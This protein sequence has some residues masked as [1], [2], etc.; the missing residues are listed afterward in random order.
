MKLYSSRHMLVVDIQVK[1]VNSSSVG[2]NYRNICFEFTDL[3]KIT[4]E[5]NANFIIKLQKQLKSN[6]ASVTSNLRDGLH[7]HLGLVLNPV[8][9]ALVVS[10]VLF[11]A[12]IDPG[13][14]VIPQV[15]TAAMATALPDQQAESVRIFREYF[16]VEKALKQQIRQA[17][18]E[19]YLL[20]IH[21]RNL[22]SLSGTVHTILN[23]LQLTY[24][25]VSVSMLFDKEAQFNALWL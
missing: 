11:L 2:I 10:P 8:D 21:D 9:Y 1:M 13:P 3:D 5:P 16:G 22:N 7:G 20:A 24:G 23:Y 25:K 4:G 12:P 19:S 15:T 18:D 17:V 14:F 6:A